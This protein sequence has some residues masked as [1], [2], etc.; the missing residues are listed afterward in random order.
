[1]KSEGRSTGIL[2]ALLALGFVLPPRVL[3]WAG[4]LLLALALASAAGMAWRRRRE[5]L[6]RNKTAIKGTGWR[7][8]DNTRPLR[9]CQ[10]GASTGICT[11]LECYD[12]R[13]CNF[14][15]KKPL[16]KM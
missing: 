8:L 14:A 13:A 4:G 6:S 5:S 11:G 16:P 2:L 3:V 7:V 15:L 10:T 1:M 12:Y 9:D